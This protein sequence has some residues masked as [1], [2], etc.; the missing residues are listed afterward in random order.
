MSKKEKKKK[1]WGKN[2]EE[3]WNKGWKVVKDG[4]D[5]RKMMG[6]KRSNLNNKYF[7]KKKFEGW[8]LHDFALN[9]SI[10]HQNNPAKSSLSYI[11]FVA[12]SFFT[13]SSSSYS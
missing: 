2:R 3:L 11:F 7:K 5:S 13:S 10:I 6:K 9:I 1:R 12:S 8:K 4:G